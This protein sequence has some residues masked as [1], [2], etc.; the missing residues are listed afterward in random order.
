M[1][2][3]SISTLRGA[4]SNPARSHLFRC[5]IT[6]SGL[7]NSVQSIFTEAFGIS[8]GETR[9][10]LCKA[11]TLPEM[12]VETGEVYYFTR[13]IKYPTRRRYAPITFTFFN[14]TDY[15]LRKAF[16]TW[17]ELLLG[18]TLNIGMVTNDV[19]PRSLG[20]LNRSTEGTATIQIQHYDGTDLNAT[21]NPKLIR[22]YTVFQAYP[23][24]VGPLTFSYDNDT[25]IQTFDVTMEYTYFSS[26]SRPSIA[27]TGGRMIPNASP[28]STPEDEGN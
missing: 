2:Q 4:I 22:E 13:A 8:T 5:V 25:E 9:S 20:N 3:F 23:S 10:Y 15:S 26:G 7:I 12:S 21:K 14:T 18:P 27:Q 6:P 11:V 16:E 19:I 24:S 17:N 1:A 28:S